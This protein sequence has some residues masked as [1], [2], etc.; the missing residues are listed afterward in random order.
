MG[1]SR[2]DAGKFLPAY[3]E[4][5]ILTKDPFVSGPSLGGPETVMVIVCFS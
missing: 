1:P 3:V 2:D 5:G 4:A